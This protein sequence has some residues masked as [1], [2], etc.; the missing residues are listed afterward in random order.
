LQ[1]TKQSTLCLEDASKHSVNYVAKYFAGHILLLV[2]DPKLLQSLLLWVRCSHKQPLLNMPW[3]AYTVANLFYLWHEMALDYKM[4][5]C[6]GGH[7]CS[8]ETGQARGSVPVGLVQ[9]G[10]PRAHSF[11]QW[12]RKLVARCSEKWWLHQYSFTIIL[13]AILAGSYFHECKCIQAE[14]T[15]LKETN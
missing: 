5:F 8:Y 15:H 10:T 13:A 7:I 2:L 1:S 11:I 6:W 3:H 12:W 14:R 9:A 4:C